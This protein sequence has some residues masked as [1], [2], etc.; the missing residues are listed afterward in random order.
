MSSEQVAQVLRQCGN[1][2]RL[3]I[4]R[5]AVE[6]PAAPT[7]CSSPCS[8]PE[9]RVGRWKQ[10]MG[11]VIVN[12]TDVQGDYFETRFNTVYALVIKNETKFKCRGILAQIIYFWE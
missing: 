11:E 6:D 3:V 2:V 4:A 10:R 1:R 5:G 9:M 12:S 7:V 8:T